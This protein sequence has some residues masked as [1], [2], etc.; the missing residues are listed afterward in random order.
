MQRVLDDPRFSDEIQV[1]VEYQIPQTAKRVDFIIAGANDADQ[2]NAIIVEL[3]QWSSSKSTPRS[4]I[5]RAFTGGEERFVP[6]PSYQA[7]SYAKTIEN[8]NSAVEELSVGLHPCS[9]LHNYAK[10]QTTG[11]EDSVYA[12]IV[13][14]APMF[15]KS[16]EKQMQDFIAGYVTRPSKTN[17]MHEM[18][19]G[20]IRPSK[21]LQDALCSMLQ[22]NEEFVL[23][24]EQKVV[25]EAVKSAMEYSLRNNKKVTIIV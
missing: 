19:N 7:Y 11:V 1:A 3:K 20:K 2:N 15:L 21:A 25:F 8:Y 22:G 24:D 17:I 10:G 12:D 13:S 4:G 6:H 5:V 14:K 23:L 16:D 18:D 9:Y